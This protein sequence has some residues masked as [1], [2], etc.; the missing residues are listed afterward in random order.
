ML[1]N[2]ELTQ[3][4]ISAVSLLVMAHS[5]GYAFERLRLPRVV[6]EICAGLLMGPSVLGL[7]LPGVAGWLVPDELLH[8][9]L[10]SAVYWMGLILLMFTAGFRVQRNFDAGE[11]RLAG[12]LLV[13]ATVVPLAAGWGATAIVDLGAYVG[14]RGSPTT[15]A[16]IFAIAVAVTSI[17]VISRIFMDLGIV[18]TRFAKVVLATATVQDVLLWAALAVATS[19]AAAQSPSLADAGLAAGRTLAFMALALVLGPPLLRYANRLRINLVLKASRL[20]YTL[21]WCFLMVALAA[22]LDVNVVFG[23]F[24]AGIVLGRMP[25]GDFDE[26]KTQI[27]SFG[28]GFFIPIYFAIVGFRIDLPGAFDP[29]LFFAF[30]GFSSAEV[31]L[32]VFATMRLGRCDSLTSWHF[33]VAMNTRG[34][35]GIVLASV[36]FDFGLIDQRLFVALVLAAIVTS[37]GAG[38]WFRYAVGAGM[39]LLDR[40]D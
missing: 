13:G 26:A 16:L 30:L 1:T 32:C 19:L 36:A 40:K 23:A 3:F 35:P 25:A 28:L 22:A 6:G 20:G 8:A 5:V 15:L 2:L 12:L 11:R 27:S 37:L 21:I 34:G 29:I 14:P 39:P 7:V 18:E 10:L 31:G 17:P 33:A 4:L 24:I 38:A 9:K